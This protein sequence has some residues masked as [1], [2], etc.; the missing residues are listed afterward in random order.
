[1]DGVVGLVTPLMEKSTDPS[2]LVTRWKVSRGPKVVGCS[3]PCTWFSSNVVRNEL[4]LKGP[5]VAYGSRVLGRLIRDVGVV[6]GSGVTGVVGLK[7]SLAVICGSIGVLLRIDWRGMLASCCRR[8]PSTQFHRP[9]PSAP[10]G[11]VLPVLLLLLTAS[12]SLLVVLVA[13][14]GVAMSLSTVLLPMKKPSTKILE[15]GF[16]V[17]VVVVVVV[18]VVG[19]GVVV[20]VVAVVEVGREEEVVIEFRSVA[21]MAAFVAMF[22]HD[23]GTLKSFLVKI[24]G[25]VVVE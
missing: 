17:S 18:V 8:F 1:M 5:T 13:G 22:F 7:K 9:V 25:G 23:S 12:V 10:S 4:A 16:S 6:E 19:E 20:V 11:C 15:N 21:A 3:M 14:L 24:L 2:S